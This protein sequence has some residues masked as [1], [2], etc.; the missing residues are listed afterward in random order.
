METPKSDESPVQKRIQFIQQQYAET[1]SCL[2]AEVQLL[3]DKNSDL[4]FRLL[5][6]D[7]MSTDL[8]EAKA[9]VV[10]LREHE[11]EVNDRNLKLNDSNLKLTETNK[12]QEETIRALE[13]E[14]SQRSA[15]AAHLMLQLH[16]AKV[17]QYG[18]A[19]TPTDSV[20]HAS[21][22][23]TRSTP[24]RP[25]PPKRPQTQT[26]DLL[27]RRASYTHVQH[28]PHTATRSPHKMFQRRATSPNITTAPTTST[29]PK[30]RVATTTTT[31]TTTPTAL[32]ITGTGTA[33][34]TASMSTS[35]RQP[36]TP[37][38]Q[39]TQKMQKPHTQKTQPNTVGELPKF[40]DPIPPINHAPTRPEIT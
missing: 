35:T 21:P 14:L 29:T 22:P 12:Q 30:M 39:Q 26:R 3:K 37:Q 40:S 34:A 13:L 10:H 8:V 18:D 23:A 38:P 6:V 15:K 36:R 16:K 11:T 32:T 24:L 25:S 28:S 19:A 20:T 17:L 5:D 31:K 27:C 9:L 1:L 33:T 7:R 2:H 4:S